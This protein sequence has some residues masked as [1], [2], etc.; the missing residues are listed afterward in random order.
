MGAMRTDIKGLMVLS[1]YKVPL[2]RSCGQIWY[3]KTVIPRDAHP[4]FHTRYAIDVAP[5]NKLVRTGW[6]MCRH[7]WG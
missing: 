3:G 2:F 1:A 4:P 7:R 6:W 5:V